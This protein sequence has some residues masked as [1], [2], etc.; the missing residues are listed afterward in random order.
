VADAPET[1][2]W[3]L[4]RGSRMGLGALVVACAIGVG[5]VAP[6][7]APVAALIAG[8]GG[9]LFGQAHG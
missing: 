3:M 1:T 9:A 5:F 4:R 2:D 7:A 8:A 6:E